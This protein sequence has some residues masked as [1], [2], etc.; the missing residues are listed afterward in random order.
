[1]GNHTD[2]I[3]IKNNVIEPIFLNLLEAVYNSS[4][5]EVDESL[6]NKPNFIN[7]IVT[8]TNQ[9]LLSTLFSKKTI[10]YTMLDILLKHGV[11]FT[12][13]INTSG[14]LP[15]DHACKIR[16]LFL[17]KYLVRHGVSISE[18]AVHKLLIKAK[19][20]ETV[21]VEE[22]FR[23]YYLINQLGG[24][25][26]VADMKDEEGLTFKTKAMQIGLINDAYGILRYD[27]WHL[28]ILAEQIQLDLNEN[29]TKSLTNEIDLINVRYHDKNKLD[30]SSLGTSLYSL[31]NSSGSSIAPADCSYSE[32]LEEKHI[33]S[34][35][36]DV[37]SL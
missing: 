26:K 14:D 30:L 21:N 23:L 6:K 15:D 11:L 34:Y 7:R 9:S 3:Y 22:I 19:K 1:M 24:M 10:D 17:L 36:P 37:S 13:S 4:Y 31:F 35:K 18:S 25:S 20:I 28:L 33:Y 32:Q 2:V 5:Q 16:D 29:A 27:L 12:Y 8:P